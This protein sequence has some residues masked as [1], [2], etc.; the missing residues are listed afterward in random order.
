MNKIG[1]SLSDLGILDAG[2]ASVGAVAIANEAAMN[3]SFLS[4]PLT[5]YATGWHTDGKK[6]EEALEFMA[7][8]VRVARRFEYFKGNNADTFAMIADNKDVRALFGEFMLV[9]TIGDTVDS[10]TVSK[11]LTTVIEKDSEMP[12][13]REEKVRWLKKILLRAECYRAWSLL[14]ASSTNAGKTWGASANPDNDLMTAIAAYGDVVGV[15]ANRVLFGATAWQKRYGAFA[16][17]D[18]KNFVPPATTEALGQFLGADVMISKER[19]TSGQGKNRIVSGNAVM[20][21]QG[22]ANATKDDPSTLKRF[23]T[24]EK[25]GQEYVVYVDE[26][27]AKLVYITVAHMSQIVATSASG[28]QKLTIS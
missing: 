22:E 15:D 26:T 1:Y 10:H 5:D 17:Q 27:K 19:Y 28:V 25:G 13:E 21:F 12:G 9:K 18:S 14:N 8:S 6:L 20:V 7:P 23:W 2:R 3:A 16:A 24:P 4:E 11:G